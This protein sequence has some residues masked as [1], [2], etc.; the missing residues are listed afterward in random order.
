MAIDC[1]GEI[2]MSSWDRFEIKFAVGGTQV[3][4]PPMTL[5]FSLLSI[6][7]F[8]AI[9]ECKFVDCFLMS[10][11]FAFRFDCDD[12]RDF[13]RDAGGCTDDSNWILSE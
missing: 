8:I 1:G 9:S 11:S 5:L 13:F 6:D 4:R 7:R 2:L 3:V 10:F 12:G